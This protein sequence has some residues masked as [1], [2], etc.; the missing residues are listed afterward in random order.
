MPDP[1]L[2]PIIRLAPAKLNLTLAVVGRREDGFHDLHSVF[3][4]LALADRLS[5][6]PARADAGDGH[7][8]RDRVR[9]RAGG[10][11]PRPARDRRGPG[12]RGGGTRTPG[13]A[14][15]RGTP[16][17]AHPGRRRARW[18]LVGRGRRLRWRARGVG[19]RAR[20]RASPARGGFDRLRRAVLPARRPGARRGA[21][22]APHAAQGRARAPGDPAGDAVDRGA[23]AGRVLGVRRD[24]R[25]GRWLDQDVVRAPGAGA[26]QRP[27]RD[28]PDRPRRGPRLSQRSAAGR[29]PRGARARG[30]EARA[31]ANADAGR[32]AERVRTDPVDALSFARRGG[33]AAEV[34]EAAVAAGT[35]PSLG[36]GPPSIIATT[37][38]TGH[39]E[40]TP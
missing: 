14:S 5:L 8:A 17:E 25:I 23:D 35:I 30:R 18:R 20:L 7:A 29:A 31:H 13:H 9:R 28:G 27:V 16:R 11:Q 4:P 15:P 12:G 32:R 37:I 26:G 34:A 1:H 21:G 36:D 2:T 3:V 6:A 33:R 38:R 22:R 10:G 39:E 24:P 40:P 19:R